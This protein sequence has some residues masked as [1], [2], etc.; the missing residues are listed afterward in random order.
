MRPTPALERRLTRALVVLAGLALLAATSAAPALASGDP[1]GAGTAIRSSAAAPVTPSIRQAPAPPFFAE[2]G[3]ALDDAR[4]AEYFA[5]RGGVRS[6][7]FPTSRTFQLLGLPSQFFQRAVLQAHP[8]GSV[9]SLNL[10]DP[11]LLSFTRINGSTFP[12]ADGRLAAAAPRP[13][14][15]NYGAAIVDFVRGNAPETFN[16]Q[17]VRFFSTFSGS[18]TFADAFPAGRGDPN[19]LPLINLEIWGV[20]TSAPAVDP[21]N[22]NFI[23]QRFQR[24]IMHYDAGCRCTQ[25]LLLA[26]YLKALITG[27]RLPA[28]LEQQ[29][30]NSPFLRQYNPDAPQGLAR[31][32]ALAGTD[33]RDAFVRL[34]GPILV[35]APAVAA[36]TP[37]RTRMRLDQG[38]WAAVDLLEGAGRMGPLNAIV[39]SDTLLEFDD[40]PPAVHAKYSRIGVGPRRAPKRTIAVSTRWREADPTALATLI[41]HEGKHLEDDLA[42][43]DVQSREGCIQFEIRAFAEQA[44]AWQEFHGPGGKAEPQ[45]DLERELNAWLAVHRRGPAELEAR[46]RQLYS[47]ACTTPTSSRSAA[48]SPR[49]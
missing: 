4:L 31:P 26:D 25:G 40:L 11:G 21:N 45:D 42:R 7:G 8:D 27:E 13:G 48:T 22:G 43:V 9:R 1:S 30:R 16:G 33:L 36:P 35:A 24:G 18:V 5:R 23:Y 34:E 39:E 44:V 2:T 28:D 17:P 46:V 6:F 37:I 49:V 38:L 20:P 10:L 14:Q 32:A 47:R 29:A 41:V 15:P 3:F 19:L 12:A